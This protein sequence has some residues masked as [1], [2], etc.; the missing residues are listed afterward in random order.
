MLIHNCPLQLK[1]SYESF[2]KRY[3]GFTIGVFYENQKSDVSSEKIEVYSANN[4]FATFLLRIVT[5]LRKIKIESKFFLPLLNY[6]R[7]L[8]FN[9]TEFEFIVFGR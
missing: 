2:G 7:C 6:I 4:A 5:I 9:N 3:R 1:I 8:Q